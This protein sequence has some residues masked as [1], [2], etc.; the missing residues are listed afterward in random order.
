ML[1]DLHLV[2]SRIIV[3]TEGK[4][5]KKAE[6]VVGYISAPFCKCGLKFVAEFDSQCN[7]NAMYVISR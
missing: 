3:L 7:N 6:C 1:I 5:R 2:T 4:V